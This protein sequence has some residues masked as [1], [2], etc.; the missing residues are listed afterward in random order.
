MA[1][2]VSLGEFDEA[3]DLGWDGLNPPPPEDLPDLAADTDAG[4]AGMDADADADA[5]ADTGM[6]AGTG[7]DSDADV[8]P[9]T[10]ANA[11]AGDTDAA[12]ADPVAGDGAAAVPA[13]PVVPPVVLPSE[14][15]PQ[16]EAAP[17]LFSPRWFQ[18][19]TQNL[20]KP[21]AEPTPEPERDATG[22]KIFAATIVQSWARVMAA[23]A[24]LAGKRRELELAELQRSVENSKAALIQGAFRD[25]PAAQPQVE[26]PP[27][28]GDARSHEQEE[29]AAMI[30]QSWARVLLAK[31]K[32]YHEERKYRLLAFFSHIEDKHAT[33][34]QR[35]YR[36]AKAMRAAGFEAATH[37]DPG[38]ESV[39]DV[40][41]PSG[42][43][44]QASVELAT[45]E[46]A[47]AGALADADVGAGAAC[48]ELGSSSSAMLQKEEGELEAIGDDGGDDGTS[49]P[50]FGKPTGRLTAAQQT[51]VE[52]IKLRQ[53]A[54]ILRR[55]SRHAIKADLHRNLNGVLW[56]RAHNMPRYQRRSVYVTPLSFDGPPSLCYAG[57]DELEKQVPLASISAVMFENEARFEFSIDATSRKHKLFFRASNEAECFMCAPC[58]PFHWPW[59][60]PLKTSRCPR[61][62]PAA[63]QSFPHGVAG[64]STASRFCFR[65]LILRTTCRSEHG[66]G[67]GRFLRYGRVCDGH[68]PNARAGGV[69]P[70]PP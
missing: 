24:V 70:A 23:R 43:P 64:G 38:V 11:D 65:S 26:L 36:A 22:S 60:P 58:P 5:D 57:P 17:G 2:Y 51:M 40:P 12:D 10:G 4:D 56:K 48:N 67:R 32:V 59:P 20:F 25:R 54:T 52:E 34:I 1:Y 6:D 16:P 45:G 29:M 49:K 47:G 7:V 55:F 8:D 15:V 19:I 46:V 30:V 53:G 31:I 66:T 28:Q 69:H 50:R 61:I 27:P 39:A 62:D 35:A 63:S 14:P 13:E 3:Y 44:P 68:F 33:N 37:S 42:L 18:Q 9:D 41:A 21:A